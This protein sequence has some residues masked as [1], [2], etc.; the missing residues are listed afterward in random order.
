M[1]DILLYQFYGQ[2]TVTGGNQDFSLWR[3]EGTAVHGILELE[4]GSKGFVYRGHHA[5]KEHLHPI[6]NP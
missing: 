1:S 2:F 5:H 6:G 4:G 3:R